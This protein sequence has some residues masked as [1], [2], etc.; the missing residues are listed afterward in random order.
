MDETDSDARELAMFF[1]RILLSKCEQL[2]AY[3]GWA[4]A[5]M[6]DEI[7]WTHQMYIPIR[8]FDADLQEVHLILVG[9]LGQRYSHEARVAYVSAPLSSRSTHIL[10]S[11]GNNSEWARL[12]SMWRNIRAPSN[13]VD[14]PMTT[15]WTR[16][17]PSAER[18][19][20]MHSRR[21]ISLLMLSCSWHSA[22]CC[23]GLRR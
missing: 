6:R 21:A 16:C 1:N 8:F 11:C 3:S 12:W 9:A 18:L 15:P 5:G 14:K 13:T 19:S 7:D 23:S 2:W 4:S 10:N 20:Y 22:S 17:N